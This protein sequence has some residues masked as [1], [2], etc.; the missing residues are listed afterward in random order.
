MNGHVRFGTFV[1]H[2]FTL[3]AQENERRHFVTFNGNPIVAS[4]VPIHSDSV[5]K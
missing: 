3:L 4:G 2:T 1:P 5:K